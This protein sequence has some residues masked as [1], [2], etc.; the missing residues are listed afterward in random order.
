[1]VFRGAINP[2]TQDPNCFLP[3][4]TISTTSTNNYAEG[5]DPNFLIFRCVKGHFLPFHS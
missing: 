3:A 5:K 4:V 1:M 2:P